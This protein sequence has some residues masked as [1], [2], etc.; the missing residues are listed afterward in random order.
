MASRFEAKKFTG[1]NDFGLWRMKIKA[2]L[3]QQGLADALNKDDPTVVLD[4]KAK[5]KRA[6]VLAKAHS[7]V[8]LSLGDKVLR[9]VSK[10]TTALGILEKCEDLYMTKSL[11]N[12]LFVKQRLYSYMFT[13][14]K[15]IM[16]QLRDFN[17]SCR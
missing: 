8:V 10:E 15:N 17:K 5:S 6:E 16:E 4:D 7:V 1:K 2:M 11:A 14:E 3:I 12:R 13:E 9:E